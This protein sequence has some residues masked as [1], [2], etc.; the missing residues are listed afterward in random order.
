M[1]RRAQH[2]QLSSYNE[3]TGHDDPVQTTD[4][5]TQRNRAVA[6]LP[7]RTLLHS[8]TR[9]RQPVR[10][11]RAPL[12]ARSGLAAGGRSGRAG[13]PVHLAAPGVSG[14]LSLRAALYARRRTAD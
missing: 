7:G 11:A 1:L 3:A 4:E 13:H 8:R 10:V 12:P 14:Q 9:Q 2:H 5:R 6:A